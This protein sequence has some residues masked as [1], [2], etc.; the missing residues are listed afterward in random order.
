MC[1][2]LTKLSE[3]KSISFG[4]LRTELGK[5]E[6]QFDRLSME[7]VKVESRFLSIED[8]SLVAM[9]PVLV[10]KSLQQCKEVGLAYLQD[11]TNVRNVMGP[12]KPPAQPK[13]RL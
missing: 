7:R 10:G 1:E 11:E 12:G 4:N 3:E 6:A 2:V 9:F 5:I 13:R 8:A